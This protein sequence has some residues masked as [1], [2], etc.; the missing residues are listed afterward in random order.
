M[1]KPLGSNLTKLTHRRSLKK[2]KHNYPRL[3]TKQVNKIGVISKIEH[4]CLRFKMLYT[5]FK[6]N[7]AF[8]QSA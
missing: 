3:K 1:L 4:N 6:A 5:G 7:I 2:N 8:Q